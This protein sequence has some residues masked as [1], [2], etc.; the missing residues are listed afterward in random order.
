L[1]DATFGLFESSQFAHPIPT[2]GV[3]VEVA[4][5]SDDDTAAGLP[6]WGAGFTLDTNDDADNPATLV[7]TR[8][9]IP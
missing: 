3:T 4:L 6:F 8:T 2:L 1:V 5:L 7:E 9:E